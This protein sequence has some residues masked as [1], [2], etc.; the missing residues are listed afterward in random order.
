[1]V[2]WSLDYDKFSHSFHKHLANLPFIIRA[3]SQ[4]PD[5]GNQ[6]DCHKVNKNRQ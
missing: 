1:M 4:M 3:L 2:D 5:P 6:D